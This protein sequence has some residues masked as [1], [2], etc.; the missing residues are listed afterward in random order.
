MET[1]FSL[2]LTK[3]REKQGISQ[4]RLCRGLCVVS[5]LS[6]YENGERI[7]DRLLM[8]ALIQR[9]GKSSDELTTMISCQEYAYFEWRRKV[10]EALRKKKISL[11]QELLQKK[12]S[13][14]GCVHSVLQEQFYRYIQG[15][16]MGTSADISDLEKAIRL[17]HPEFSGK[18]EEEDLFSIHELNLLLFYAKCKIQKEVEQGREL[19][20]ALLP[21][22]QEHITDIQAKNQIFPR[23]VCLY[24]RYVTGE[25]NAQKRYLLCREAFENSRK[26]QRFEYTV[27]L[28][29]YMRKDAIC[30]G[31]EFEAVSYQVWKKILEAMYQEY[32]VEIPQAEWGIEIPQ[33]L[34]LIPEI[35]LSARVEQG[36]SQEEISEGICTPE[37]YS[38]IETG[39]RSPSLKN[40]EALK[41][42]LKIRSGYYMGEV[43]TEDFAV[44][45]LVQELRAAVSASNLKAWEMCQQRLEEKLDLSK[46]INRQ[47]TEGYRTCLEYQKGKFLEDEWIRRH[48]KTLSYT[49]KEPMEQRMFCEERAHVFTN[50]ETILLQQI[51]LA[52][53][54]RGEKEKAVEIWELLLKDYGRSR[55]RMENHFKEVMLIWSN[56]ANTLPDVGKTKEGIALADQGIRMVLEKGQGSLNMLF[57]N[58]IYAMKEAGQ[59][60][61]KEQFEQAYA[62][63]E[64]FGDLELQNSLKYYIQKNWPSKEKIH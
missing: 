48:R 19:L 16:L 56:L 3:E 2:F 63:S 31:K 32:G 4:E 1:I 47:Y 52:E 13:L 34:F 33:N 14:D 53:K 9:L 26:D 8:N 25:A 45:E 28:L 36:A 49:R 64:M 24:C 10:K 11:A 57:A 41:S 62:L 44:L 12:E 50:T 59:D 7:P 55:I 18:I 42:R 61:R 51:A 58:R 60:V 5:A 40:L 39:K 30:L 43:W 20:E 15:I 54:I 37:T 17:T 29:G 27:E 22:I 35:L 38:R 23:A 6:R 21:Y 46:K